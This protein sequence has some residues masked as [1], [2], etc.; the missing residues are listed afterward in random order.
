MVVRASVSVAMFEGLLRSLSG[1]IAEL[2]RWEISVD[3]GEAYIR[4]GLENTILF[5]F[6]SSSLLGISSFTLVGLVESFDD[7]MYSGSGH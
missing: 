1:S 3:R 6:C 4:A 2:A 7:N 5:M